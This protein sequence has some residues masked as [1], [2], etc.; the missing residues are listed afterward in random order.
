MGNGQ[1]RHRINFGQRESLFFANN[2]GGPKALIGRFNTD[3]GVHGGA[4][5]VVKVV[6]H[7]RHQRDDKDK[8]K[9]GPNASP[10]FAIGES[11]MMEP[12]RRS[13]QSKSYRIERIT[14][15]D[16][17]CNFPNKKKIFEKYF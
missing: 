5:D 11:I 17:I 15:C 6:N 7:A 13:P 14:H 16:Q 12:V 8:K 3:S 2:G 4:K 1:R 9:K 10:A